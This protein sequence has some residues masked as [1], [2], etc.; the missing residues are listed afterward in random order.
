MKILRDTLDKF[1]PLFTK[2]GK[3]EKL[4]PVYEAADTFLYTPGHRTASGPSVRDG[5]DLKRMMIMVVIALIPAT[6]FGMWNVGFQHLR[7]TQDWNLAPAA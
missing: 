7:A 6:L 5:I 3:L 1:E 2:G 4:Y